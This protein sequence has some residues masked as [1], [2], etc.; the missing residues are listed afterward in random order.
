MSNTLAIATTTVFDY[1]VRPDGT[2]I[3]GAVVELTLEWNK[4]TYNASSAFANV[5]QSPVKVFTDSNGYW[6]ATLIRNSDLVNN[7]SGATTTNYLVKTPSKRQ[8]I[9]VPAGAGPFQASQI[10]AT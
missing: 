9:T 10:V 3:V 6:Q 4:A 5:D 7:P 2:P 8:R 1:E